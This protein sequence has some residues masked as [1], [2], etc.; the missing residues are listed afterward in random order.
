M[1]YNFSIVLFKNNKRYKIIKKYQTLENSLKKWNSLL[2]ENKNVLFGVKTEN[3]K[4]VN[5]ELGL[6][7]KGIKERIT[8]TDEFGRN[9]YVN[10]EDSEYQLIKISEFNLSEKIFDLQKNKRID[11][12]TFIK[13]YSSTESIQM[14]FKLNNK[15]VI[16]EDDSFN[17]FS[18]K[19]SD[20]AERFL[21][22]LKNDNKKNFLLVKDISIEQKKYLY[23]LLSE[24]GFNKKMLYRNSTTHLKDI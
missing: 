12:E 9:V 18:L 17:L 21:D 16:Q 11:Y 19:S 5:Y 24:K 13:S 6:I 1:Q 22:C 20:D 15:I 23:N 4:K 7:G 8:Q 14:I 2:D 3:G 10:L